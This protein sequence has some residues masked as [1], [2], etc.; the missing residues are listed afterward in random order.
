MTAVR[1]AIGRPSV[2]MQW[3]SHLRSGRATVGRHTYGAPL[4][5]LAAGD[6]QAL[7]VGAFT[8]VSFDVAVMLGGNHRTDWVTTFPVRQAF[9]LPEALRDGHPSSKGP[10]TIGNDVW[11]GRGARILSGV[12]IGDGAVVGAHAVVARSVRPY[13]VVVGNPA[14]EVRRRFPDPVVASL[15]RIA[16]WDWPDE[17]VVARVGQ[18]CSPDV[19]AFCSMYDPDYGSAHSLPETASQ[20]MSS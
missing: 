3:R 5:Q 4:L 17:L 10:V 11:I 15:L 1:R 19:E 2:E 18:L 13:A 8:S 6:E 12:S 20:R 7:S 16:W 14:R 9:G